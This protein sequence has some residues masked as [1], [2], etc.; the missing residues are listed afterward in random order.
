MLS[1][2]VLHCKAFTV[3][4]PCPRL[5]VLSR[6]ITVSAISA[7]LANDDDFFDIVNHSDRDR[8]LPHSLVSICNCDIPRYKTHFFSN[9]FIIGSDEVVVSTLSR[10]CK[11]V[12]LVLSFIIRGI[13][14]ANITHKLSESRMK[15]LQRSLSLNV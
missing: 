9:G 6:I 15:K 7:C 8:V 5:R 1:V 12:L 10:T 3:V 2:V 11:I 13:Q 14:F 4:L